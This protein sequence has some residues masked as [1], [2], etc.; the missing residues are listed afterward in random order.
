MT[1]QTELSASAG[2][3]ADDGQATRGEVVGYGEPSD[4]EMVSINRFTR[5]PLARGDV[6]VVDSRPSDTSIDSYFTRMDPGTTLTNYAEDAQAGVPILNSHGMARGM[7]ASDLPIG[8]SFAGQVLSEDY[9]T[10]RG[11]K[12]HATK[13]KPALYSAFYLPRGL[14]TSTTSN[15]DM[16]RAIDSGVLSDLSVQFG[17]TKPRNNGYWYR[18]DECGND[19]LRSDD[20]THFPGMTLTKDGA[21]RRVSWTVMDAGLKEYS[22]VWRGSNPTAEM[23]RKMGDLVTR[24]MLSHA[25]VSDIDRITGRH[26]ATALDWEALK[27]RITPVTNPAPS[28]ADPEVTTVQTG[29]KPPPPTRQE[30]TDPVSGAEDA[31]R[32][33]LG[34][35]LGSAPATPP[36][37]TGGAVDPA[38]SV[39]T[40]WTPE[41]GLLVALRGHGVTD[42]AGL[43]A[44]VERAADG[45][46]YRA[47]L[48]ELCHREAVGVYGAEY[49]RT[50][51][52]KMLSN[53]SIG[54]LRDELSARQAAKRARFAKDD[55]TEDPDPLRGVVAARHGGRQ[56]V[57]GS[58]PLGDT[59]RSA[60]DTPAAR[61][62]DADLYAM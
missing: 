42:D 62:Q 11:A 60:E 46:I 15:D 16:I 35:A 5:R 56:T 3:A 20:C 10:P 31:R 61:D 23:L 43:R 59:P 37:Q 24:G 6:Y 30:G 25:D 28:R 48:V 57:P 53:L 39:P 2:G 8:R 29:P 49:R 4:E 47:D 9:T 55:P 17:N 14:Q 33:A 51:N 44:L 26:M 41:A 36:A 21:S 1:T 45:Q 18:C 38:S 13:T 34:E 19:G 58:S 12:L 7:G 52:D 22:P 50:V 40:V 32:A 27:G 54:E